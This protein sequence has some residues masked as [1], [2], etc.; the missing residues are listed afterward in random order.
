[1]TAQDFSVSSRVECF[2]H[3]CPE[4]DSP[5][6]DENGKCC[7]VESKIAQ[8]CRQEN[9]DC[10]VNLEKLSLLWNKVDNIFHLL[11]IKGMRWCPVS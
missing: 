3:G 10:V 8:Q 4:A 6:R 7:K 2:C 9:K 1:M 5:L 11:K